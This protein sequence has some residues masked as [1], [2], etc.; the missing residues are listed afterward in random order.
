MIKGYPL[1]WGLVKPKSFG[2]NVLFIKNRNKGEDT[3][4]LPIASPAICAE[5]VPMDFLSG[6]KPRGVRKCSSV[7]GPKADTASQY[8]NEWTI[9]CPSVGCGGHL[10]AAGRSAHGPPQIKLEAF[11]A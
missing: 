5:S 1:Y 9:A 11:M 7:A 4:Q 8:K 10:P 6:W 3:C 2:Y